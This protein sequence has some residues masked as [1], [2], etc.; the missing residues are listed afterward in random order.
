MPGSPDFLPF[1]KDLPKDTTSQ[2]MKGKA[3]K[4]VKG[5]GGGGGGGADAAAE[6]V[7]ELKV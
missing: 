4:A 6:K 7:K 2:R 3:E 5:G 1:T